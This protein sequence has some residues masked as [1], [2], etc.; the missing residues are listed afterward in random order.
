MCIR[1]HKVHQDICNREVLDLHSLRR[2]IKIMKQSTVIESEFVHSSF[3]FNSTFL[4]VVVPNLMHQVLEEVNASGIN[5]KMR[6][7]L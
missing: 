7:V 6:H 5:V 3:D 4:A 1:V 2:K